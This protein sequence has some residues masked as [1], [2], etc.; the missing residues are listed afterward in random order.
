MTYTSLIIL[1]GK[2]NGI[3]TFSY[4]SCFINDRSCRG[5]EI[6][7]YFTF[8]TNEYQTHRNVSVTSQETVKLS[9]KTKDVEKHPII[10]INK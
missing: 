2:Y 9:I 3:Q 10:Y 4:Q 8:I 6:K 1:I 5:S 7:K